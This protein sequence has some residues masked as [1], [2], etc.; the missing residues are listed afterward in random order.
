MLLFCNWFVVIL[1]IEYITHSVN[2]FAYFF[3][4][5]MKMKG[6]KNNCHQFMKRLELHVQ[7]RVYLF[8]P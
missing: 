1:I 3:Q 7:K 5:K 2:D 6:V 4:Q 8:T